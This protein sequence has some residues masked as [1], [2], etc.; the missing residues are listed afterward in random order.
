MRTLL[1]NRTLFTALNTKFMY[2]KITKECQDS[3]SKE[4]ED[5]NL[6]PTPHHTLWRMLSLVTTLAVNAGARLG[7]PFNKERL[8]E[9]K[10]PP[11]FCC[12]V[13]A[14]EFPP[15]ELALDA[16]DGEGV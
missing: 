6:P 16:G 8:P 3:I 5:H 14:G 10:V 2:S 4:G 15:S 12:E 13:L 1:I 9:V 7:F 11:P